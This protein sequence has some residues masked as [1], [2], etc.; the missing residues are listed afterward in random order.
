[1]SPDGLLS[2]RCQLAAADRQSPK[3]T[4]S[5]RLRRAGSAIASIST[6]FWPLIVKP[7]TIR[8][9]PRGV[10]TTPTAPLTSAGRAARARPL[11]AFLA[12]ACNA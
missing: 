7:S 4:R 5:S 6:I 9:R 3:R 11:A 12:N 2:R 1:M 10:T 8:S